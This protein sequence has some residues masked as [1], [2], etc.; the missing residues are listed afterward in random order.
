MKICI[1][2]PKSYPLFN[3]KIK[4]TFGGAEVQLWLI[5]EEITKK[6]RIEVNFMVADYGQT[7]REKF[8]NIEVW[9]SVNLKDLLFKQILSFF[10]TFYR[11]NADYYFQQTLTPFSGLIALYCKLTRKKFIFLLANDGEADRSHKIYRNK[12]KWIL[13]ELV[14]RFSTLIITQNDY[15][16]EKLERR[17][18][19][20]IVLKTGYDIEDPLKITKKY[21]LWVGRSHPIKRPLLFIDLAEKNPTLKFVM[22]C[23]QATSYKKL[24]NLINF[25]SKKLPNLEFIDFIPFNRIGKYFQEALIFINTSSQEGFPNTFIQAAMYK[26]P[27]ISLNVNPSKFLTKYE[28]G[29]I[30]N[31][32]YKILNENLKELITNHQL[33]QKMS[34]NAYIY[35]KKNHDIKVIVDKI[36]KQILS[37]KEPK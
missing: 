20:S 34:N 15:Q 13:A 32:D 37:T 25:K 35:V 10:K 12:T 16:Q 22:I 26:T 3:Q 27:I 36:I 2:A 1:I 29:F 9:K 21:I 17:D 8:G 33:Y 11:I 30:C 23:P 28:C 5:G 31:D 19:K 7:N 18:I 14:F 24:H 6:K 4:S